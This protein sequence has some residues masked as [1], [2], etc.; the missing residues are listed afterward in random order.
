MYLTF[1]NL[2]LILFSKYI[3][4]YINILLT[5]LFVSIFGGYIFWICPNKFTLK[6]NNFDYKLNKIELKITDILFHQLPLIIVIYYY[7]NYYKINPFN[8]SFY[9]ALFILLMYLVLFNVE[10]IYQLKNCNQDKVILLNIIIIFFIYTF[11]L[12]I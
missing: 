2:I 8:K 10:Y 1:I 9:N 6:F 7:I 3:Y 12:I 4:K 11:I 5:T